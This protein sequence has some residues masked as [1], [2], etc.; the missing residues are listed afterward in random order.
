MCVCCRCTHSCYYYHSNSS[1]TRITH[2]SL[3]PGALLHCWLCVACASSTAWRPLG[4]ASRRPASSRRCWPAA[5]APRRRPPPTPPAPPTPRAPSPRT[6][7][8]GTHT[9]GTHALRGHLAS[10]AVHPVAL[11]EA[12]LDARGVTGIEGD[13]AARCA[14]ARE[15]LA[16]A[17]AKRRAAET[18]EQRHARSPP[19]R[20]GGHVISPATPSL[21]PW[22]KTSDWPASV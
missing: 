2:T 7:R 21:R 6:L 14:A 20:A 15:K 10:V 9:D 22:P 16:E 8:I 1:N 5:A 18:E 11:D 19:A 17:K 13:L 3:P 12:A 4:P